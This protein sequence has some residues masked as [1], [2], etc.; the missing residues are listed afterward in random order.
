MSKIKELGKMSK[1]N[2]ETEVRRAVTLYLC[3][4]D[5]QLLAN[6]LLE[7]RSRDERPERD[8]WRREEGGIDTPSWCM[9]MVSRLG[10]EEEF[11]G[12]LLWAATTSGDV[13]EEGPQ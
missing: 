3:V 13:K 11:A 9:H 10:I 8:G 5:R 12:E 1:I 7:A 4:H 6:L 2:H